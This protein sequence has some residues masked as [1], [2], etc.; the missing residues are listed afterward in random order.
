MHYCCHNTCWLVLYYL[1]AVLKSR[2]I[3]LNR[4]W[5]ARRTKTVVVRV[6]C[7]DMDIYIM[8]QTGYILSLKICSLGIYYIVEQNPKY[9][10]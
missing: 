8:T 6:K 2:F 1:T 4:Q 9:I 10:A 3:K 7:L 5:T